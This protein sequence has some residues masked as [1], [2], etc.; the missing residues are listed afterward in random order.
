LSFILVPIK[1]K[2]VYDTVRN[3]LCSRFL[4]CKFLTER[5]KKIIY[6]IS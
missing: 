5:E 1:C 6:Y 4:A 3:R 2:L